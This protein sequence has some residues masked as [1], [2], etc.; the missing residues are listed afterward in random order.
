MDEAFVCECGNKKFWF[1]WDFVRCT[2]CWNEYKKDLIIYTKFWPWSKDKVVESKIAA[3]MTFGVIINV[4]DITGL[5]PLKEF[6]RQKVFINNF[7][8]NDKLNV[9]F[10]EY[11]D[12]KILFCL[13]DI[14]YKSK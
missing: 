8:V 3:V 6:K 11:K 7:V 10:E 5:V 13:P 4:G 9:M 2:N 1:F 14:T 12:G